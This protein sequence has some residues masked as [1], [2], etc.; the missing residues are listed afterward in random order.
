M[1]RSRV[2]P[3][4]NCRIGIDSSLTSKS[5]KNRLWNNHAMLKR[6]KHKIA[7]V[8]ENLY[9]AQTIRKWVDDDVSLVELASDS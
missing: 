2:N 5:R 6:T 9:T 3:F 1:V 8:T 4:R 7:L